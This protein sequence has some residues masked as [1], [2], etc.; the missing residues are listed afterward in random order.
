MT[1]MRIQIRAKNLLIIAAVMLLI[2]S[3][4]CGAAQPAV[5]PH[6]PAAQS[7]KTSSGAEEPS[8]EGS[9]V[10]GLRFVYD[11]FSG[12]Q[13]YL[14]AYVENIS[15]T[16]ADA[17]IEKRIGPMNYTGHTKEG[18]LTLTGS[19]AA[20]LLEI[21]S[22]YDLEAWSHLPASGSGSAPSR[23]L[24]VF[25][26]DDILYD[27]M[28]NAKFPQTLP[29]EE[30]VMYFELFNFFNDILEEE[31]GW[32]EV[33]SENLE[34]PRENPAYYER[35]VTW[36]GNDVRLVPGTGAWYE[37][38]RYAEIDYEGR[39]WWIEEGFTGTW[40]LDEENPT[41]GLNP[42][43]SASLAVYENGSVK[44]VLDGEEWTGTVSSV[45]RYMDSADIFLDRGADSRSCSVETTY[46]EYYE[47]IH[48]VCYPGPVPEI[49]FPPIDVYLV[50]S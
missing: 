47:R 20:E 37:D 23:S 16:G 3:S 35:R 5:Q 1:I 28:W 10:T 27:V 29:P 34:D 30:D 50:R 13:F 46:E 14:N 15:G 44:F 22:R 19:Q 38:G 9:P 8:S 26:G 17:E 49:Q 31:P 24:I 36:F 45:R 39:D 7:G 2:I 4:G 6:A 48:V 32:E 25:S 43:G 11:M 21:L 18:N 42:P 12:N 33:R 40:T 41:N